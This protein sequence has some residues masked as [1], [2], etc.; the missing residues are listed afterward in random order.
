MKHIRKPQL[1]LVALIVGFVPLVTGVDAGADPL[2]NFTSYS[3]SS[4]IRDQFVEAS[5]GNLWAANLGQNGIAKISK[6]GLLTIYNT[7]PYQ[8][9]FSRVAAGPNGN[10]WFDSTSYIGHTTSGVITTFE[11]P[12]SM[13]AG[14]RGITVGPDGNIWFAQGDGYP[15]DGKIGRMTPTGTFLSPYPMDGHYPTGIISDHVNN[16]IWYSVRPNNT[17]DPHRIGKFDMAGSQTEFTLPSTLGLTVSSLIMGPDGNL[18]FINGPG[19][20]V[21]MTPTGTFTAYN[22]GYSSPNGLLRITSGLDGYIWATRQ[23]RT[24]A[25]IS[26]SGSATI[27]TIYPP[28]MPYA[29]NVGGLLGSRDGNVWVLGDGPNQIIKVGT[30]YTDNDE[31]GLEYSQEISQGTMDNDPDSDEDGLSDYVESTSYPARDQ[32]FCNSSA[33]YCEHPDPTAKDLYIENDWMVKPGAGGYSMQLS[34]VQVSA[35]QAAFA[36]ENI[37]LHIDTGQLGGGTQVPYTSEI[38]FAPQTGVTDFYDYKLGGD[39]ITAQMSTWRK[40]IFHYLLAGQ[41]YSEA[42]G[43]T[44]VSYAGDDDFF[45]AYGNIKENLSS[46]ALDTAISSTVIH[47]LGHG[48][49]LTDENNGSPAYSGQPA[50][51]RF[52]GVDEYYSPSYLSAMNYNYQLYHVDYS[53]GQSGVDDHDDWGAI[54]LDDF[55]KSTAGDIAHGGAVKNPTFKHG[56][57][58]KRN[59]KQERPIIGPSISNLKANRH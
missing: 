39:G 47:E 55:T 38:H 17:G 56:E 23:G 41:K 28:S 7:T 16:A 46:S 8:K 29:N 11:K 49:C 42:P 14:S 26:T 59:S 25:R 34:S 32:T 36:G 3:L 58:K 54:R 24:V 52:A 22:L 2:G 1:L 57:Y 44:G 40:D 19:K 45:V 35:L 4:T 31:D 53:K 43:S 12:Q 18:W 20:I 6:T 51:C 37:T 10:V 50:S 33:S 30:G 21:K 13:R 48:L 15:G 27:Y 5:D 9:S